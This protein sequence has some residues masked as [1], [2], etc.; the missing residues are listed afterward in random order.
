M[1]APTNHWKLGLFVV[2]GGLVGLGAVVFLGSLSMN[3]ENV[4]YTSYFDESVTGL[5]LGS[6][7]K[8]RGVTVGTVSAIE[9][10]PDRRHVEVSYEL[11][12]LVLERL[13]IASGKGLQTKLRIPVDLR[14]Q[15]G[16]SGLSG[17]KY[18][19]I[20][21]FDSRTH[22]V[23]ELSF[24]VPKNY[25]PG[26]P[27]TMKN[28]ESSVVRAVDQFPALAEEMLRA[29]NQVNAILAD[30]QGQK[31]PERAIATLANV[32]HTLLLLQAKMKGV[33][34]VAL[35]ADAR[36]LIATLDKTAIQAQAALVSMQ[37]ASDSVGDVAGNARNVGPDLSHTLRDISEAAVSL[38]QLLEAL[39]LDSDML[40]KGRSVAP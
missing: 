29:L 17:L 19:L 25:I 6:T 34:T 23:P 7:V 11:R 32:D 18:I 21:Y 5:D 4:T 35:S 15:L 28:L 16:S 26:E 3:D 33:D 13:G 39:E 12:V 31:V 10:A 36:K 9:V 1:S 20:D 37:R 14:A 24:P 22:P 40:V 38:Q 2:V 30:I 27:S 8:F